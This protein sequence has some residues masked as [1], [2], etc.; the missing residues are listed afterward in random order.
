MTLQEI[1]ARLF[2]SVYRMR[3]GQLV[4]ITGFAFIG[5][6]LNED[7]TK[8][9]MIHTWNRKMNFFQLTHILHTNNMEQFDCVELVKCPTDDAK[10]K[11]L[12][13]H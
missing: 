7:N 3:T 11:K 2:P 10:D 12:V 5:V 4:E 6:L 9:D 8:Q 1:E 13:N